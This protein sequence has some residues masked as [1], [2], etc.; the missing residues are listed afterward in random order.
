MNYI[1]DAENNGAMI[2]NDAGMLPKVKDVYWNE[3]GNSGYD[4]MLDKNGILYGGQL[5]AVY[6][7]PNRFN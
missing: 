2:A 5:P 7:K 6:V 1:I 4:L 3:N